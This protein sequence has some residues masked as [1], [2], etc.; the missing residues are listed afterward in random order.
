MLAVG[1]GTV[2]IGANDD[3]VVVAGGEGIG[4][5][6]ADDGTLCWTESVVTLGKSRGYARPGSVQHVTVSDTLVYLS[7]APD[8]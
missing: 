2:A 3:V 7:T 8:T 4:V 5:L 1:T 6:D